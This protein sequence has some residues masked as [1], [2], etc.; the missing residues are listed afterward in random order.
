MRCGKSRAL[1]R[2]KKAFPASLSNSKKKYEI[3]TIQIDEDS[4]VSMSVCCKLVDGLD[5]EHFVYKTE[6]V[7][8]YLD[9]NGKAW[10]L[11]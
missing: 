1:S 8:D 5:G 6:Q 11:S 2:G 9:D 10:F 7:K 4:Y 3:E